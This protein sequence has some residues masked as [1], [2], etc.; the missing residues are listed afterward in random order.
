MERKPKRASIL[1]TGAPRTGTTFA[2]ALLGLARGVGV[3][4]EPFHPD[5]G[6][7]GITGE[8]LDNGLEPLAAPLRVEFPFITADHLLAP[9][10]DRL[11]RDAIAGRAA[12]QRPQ[13]P[14]R[15]GRVTALARRLFTSRLALQNRWAAA[16]PFHN[17][18]I[19][20]DPHLCLA[21]EHVHR[22]MGAP[23][24]VTIRHPLATAESW[25]RLG[26][27][28]DLRQFWRQTALWE[29]HLRGLPQPDQDFLS[30]LQRAAYAWLWIHKVLLDFGQRNPDMMFVR[31]EDAAREPVPTFRALY[32]RL[33]LVFDA[34]IENAIRARTEAKTD[35][36]GTRERP[37]Q[38]RRDSR[39]VVESWKG[40]LSEADQAA[41]RR[42]V[43]ATAA[44]WYPEEAW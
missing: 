22:A 28:P 25:T 20:K 11:Y 2:G 9:R 7:A 38:L 42:I 34:R 19:V 15:H 24:L 17:R 6:V 32:E 12:Y 3:I 36:V 30:P 21:S 16:W 43:S 8:M 40:R 29:R 23:C 18:W 26:W 44:A 27:N 14:G 33:G 1:V 13:Y 37:H 31:L 35:A 4:F 10:F 41:V 39:S 5:A